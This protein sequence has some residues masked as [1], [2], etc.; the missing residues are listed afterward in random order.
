MAAEDYRFLLMPRK[1]LV[2]P[3]EPAARVRAVA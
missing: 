1:K 3:V 2:P